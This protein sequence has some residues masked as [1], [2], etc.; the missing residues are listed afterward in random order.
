MRTSPPR[1]FIVAVILLIDAGCYHS[2]SPSTTKASPPSPQQ[3]PV[4]YDEE[5][6]PSKYTPALSELEFTQIVAKVATCTKDPIW[7]IRV[8]PYLDLDGTFGHGT[9]IVYLVP[10][11]QMSR[12]REG[13][14]YIVSTYDK[15]I[16]IASSRDGYVQVSRPDQVLTTELT[17]PSP[18]D[19]PF[20]RPDSIDPNAAKGSPMPDEEL[21]RILDFVRRPSTYGRLPDQTMSPEQMVEELLKMPFLGLRKSARWRDNIV[22][23]F[24]FQHAPRFGGGV[25]VMI[26]PTPTGYEA[27]TWGR[28]RS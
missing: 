22:V 6:V 27:V 9:V 4:F 23:Y 8:K 28:W 26:K 17:L 13:H 18:S 15:A 25:L 5:G 14:A 2:P 1:L 7:F 3:P 10:E 24:G 11:R 12:I 21:I 16:S 20:T 19:L